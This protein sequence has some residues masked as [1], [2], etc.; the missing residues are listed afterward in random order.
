MPPGAMRAWLVG[1]VGDDQLDIGLMRDGTQIP[2][3]DLIDN[4]TRGGGQRRSPCAFCPIGPPIHGCGGGSAPPGSA[5]SAPCDSSRPHL[6]PRRRAR[7]LRRG[8][9]RPARRRSAH[10]AAADDVDLADL[11]FTARD[12]LAGPGPRARGPI[13]LH[14]HSP[15]GLA[16]ALYA[17]GLSETGPGPRRLRRQGGGGAPWICRSDDHCE[18]S[19]RPSAGSAGTVASGIV[20]KSVAH[21]RARCRPRSGHRA[22]RQF[23]A[24]SRDRTRSPDRSPAG[25]AIHPAGGT[26]DRRDR[27][28]SEAVVV[29]HRT[30][31][32]I[33]RG[34]EARSAKIMATM[35]M[36]RTITATASCT[37]SATSSIT[38]PPPRVTHRRSTPARE[39]RAS[40]RPCPDARR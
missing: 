6:R 23:R 10:A 5:S 4:M 8:R 34:S 25:C 32:S 37:V 2:H 17:I 14:G 35:N 30:S 26:L 9:P 39:A 18:A 29:R 40:A 20:K 24:R 22:V 21:D 13:V 15:G 36:S 33:S 7:R 16:T 28:R 12:G 3:R 19:R 31:R 11:T 27:S 38:T 1:G